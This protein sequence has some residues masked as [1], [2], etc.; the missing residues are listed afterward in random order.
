MSAP[1]DSHA[2]VPTPDPRTPRPWVILI[3][4]TAAGDPADVGEKWW[5]CES[6]FWRHLNEQLAPAIACASPK[7]GVFHWSGANS[8]RARRRA[9]RSLYEWL[10]KLDDDGR[11]Y[12]LV[13][14]SHGG[15]IIWHALLEATAVGHP[16]RHM[17]TWTTVATPFMNYRPERTIFFA[18]VP[19]IVALVAAVASVDRAQV[20]AGLWS[21]IVDDGAIRSIVSLLSLWCVIGFVLLV[22]GVQLIRAMHALSENKR[23]DALAKTAWNTYGDKWFG[24]W[25]AE[26]EAINGL[27]STLGLRGAIMPRTK[28]WT[29]S[30]AGCVAALVTAP[31]R[32]IYDHVIAPAGDQFIWTRVTRRMQ[33]AD[34][35]AAS[36]ASVTRGPVPEAK[37]HAL[38]EHI[39]TELRDRA[40]SEASNALGGMRREMARNQGEGLIARFQKSLTWRELIH[41]S[42]FDFGSVREILTRRIS[43]QQLTHDGEPALEP[44]VVRSAAEGR[45]LAVWAAVAM[46]SAVAFA[47]LISGTIYDNGVATYR[48]EYQIEQAFA[49][50]PLDDAVEA[51]GINDNE[52]LANWLDVLVV[53]GR[54]NDVVDVATR[55]EAALGSA[56]APASGARV[57]PKVIDLIFR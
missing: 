50:T 42:Y 6:P 47:Q 15:S 14:H 10:K 18:L 25:S 29:A 23:R 19:F 45:L 31:F 9:G 44:V 38:A 35:P 12:H 26:D 32:W 13:A 22:S 21:A 11:E 46:M 54:W 4:G 17:Q 56:I 7:T 24:I 52:V 39:T 57:L 53:S 5:Q 34:L 36:L 49:T 2:D 51:A 40:N 8:E 27:A 28:E 41:N 55:H 43:G 33:G 20:L 37:T 48:D 30:L 3:H 16:L 1:S